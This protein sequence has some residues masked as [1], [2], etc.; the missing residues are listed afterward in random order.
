MKHPVH[1]YAPPAPEY[2][3]RFH[4][5]LAEYHSRQTFWHRYGRAAQIILGCVVGVALAWG[6]V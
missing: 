2:G 6:L 3:T 5:V 1:L 4:R